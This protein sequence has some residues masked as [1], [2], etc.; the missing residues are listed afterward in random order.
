MLK[1]CLCNRQIVVGFLEAIV[2]CNCIH[3]GLSQGSSLSV[4][5]VQ[6]FIED[7]L[8]GGRDLLF[9]HDCALFQ[10]APTLISCLS[11]YL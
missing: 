10:K 2:C 4:W 6:L 3:S 9:I 1:Y 11:V 5:L 8:L 7:I